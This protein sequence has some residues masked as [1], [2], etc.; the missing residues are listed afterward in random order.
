MRYSLPQIIHDVSVLLDL[1]GEDLPLINPADPPARTIAD[2]ILSQVEWGAR[3]AIEEAPLDKLGTGVPIHGG[4][5]WHAAPGVGKGLLLLPDDFLRLLA[6]RMSDWRR[7]AKIITALDEEY[8]WQ[9]SRFAAIRGNPE[10]PVAAIITSPLGQAVEL[11]SSQAG[12]EVT[13][14]KALYLPVPRITDGAI[15]LPRLLYPDIL[16]R[17]ATLTQ[18]SYVPFRP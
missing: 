16:R 2:I 7:D 9:S 12:P 14:A 5:A 1:D 15:E 11:Y 4:V 13:I 10:R 6:I 18:Q 8:Q 17:I 3:Q